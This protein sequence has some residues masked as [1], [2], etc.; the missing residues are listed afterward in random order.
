MLFSCVCGGQKPASGSDLRK[1]FT[2]IFELRSLSRCL[3]LKP[4]QDQLSQASCL[5]APVSF[6]TLPQHW[7]HSHVLPHRHFVQVLGPNAG[8]HSLRWAFYIS[9]TTIALWIY[10]QTPSLPTS[11]PHTDTYTNTRQSN[12]IVNVHTHTHTHRDRNAHNSRRRCNSFSYLFLS[13]SLQSVLFCLTLLVSWQKVPG[14]SLQGKISDRSGI[15][16]VSSSCLI[17]SILF[18]A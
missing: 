6:L 7:D 5:A 14:L 10:R 3:T 17:H 8:L 11:F 9:P 12:S 18:P 2:Q 1:M 4:G 13:H 15:N 16:S